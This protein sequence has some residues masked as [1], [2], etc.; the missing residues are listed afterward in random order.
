MADKKELRQAQTVFNSLCKALDSDGWH[1]EKDEEEMMIKCGAQGEDVPIA[2]I[3]NVDADEAMVSLYSQLQ[4]AI[5]ED[6]RR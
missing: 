2:M 1:Y 6:S 5:A 4:F 3:I